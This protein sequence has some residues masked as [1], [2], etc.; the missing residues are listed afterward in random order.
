M[1]N[2]AGD[3]GGYDVQ[4]TIEGHAAPDKTDEEYYEL[5]GSASDDPIETHWNLDRLLAVYR[6]K[7]NTEK[8]VVFDRNLSDGQGNVVPG[9]S[10]APRNP[11]FGVESWRN[12]GLIWTRN[13]VAPKLPDSV[14]RELGSIF[15]VLPGRPTGLQ[16]PPGLNGSRDWLCIRIR[17]SQQD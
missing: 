7:L 1:R 9:N 13:W 12:P 14:V 16:N 6:G 2:K 4:V 8:R 5:E 15:G 3:Q 10:S 17:A 11:M